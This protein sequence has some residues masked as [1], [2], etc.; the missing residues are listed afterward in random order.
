MFPVPHLASFECFCREIENIHDL[1]HLIFSN[2]KNNDTKVKVKFPPV[3]SYVNKQ[4]AMKA[5][6]EMEV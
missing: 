4:Y 1:R 6:G 2:L 5:Y 3:F